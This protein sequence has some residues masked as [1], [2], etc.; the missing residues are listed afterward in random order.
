MNSNQTKSFDSTQGK[1]PSPPV[2][3]KST[4]Y[5]NINFWS[6]VLL[7]LDRKIQFMEENLAFGEVGLTFI[8]HRGRI[9]RIIWKD[10][11]SDLVLVEKSGGTNSVIAE[12][13]KYGK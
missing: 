2:P 8:F 13:K 11:L 10:D 3:P 1:I 9:H 5:K 7:R 4:L 6:D 12:D